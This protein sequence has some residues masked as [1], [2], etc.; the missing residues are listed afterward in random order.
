MQH[1]T[2]TGAT[3]TNYLLEKS[4]VAYVWKTLEGGGGERAVPCV[5]P[6]LTNTGLCYHAVY[7]VLYVL[8]AG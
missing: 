5:D 1:R 6:V 4:R 3:T 8:C 7:V 2:I